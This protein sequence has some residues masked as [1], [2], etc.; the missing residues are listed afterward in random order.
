M[1]SMSSVKGGLEEQIKLLENQIKIEE[2]RS[3]LSNVSLTLHYF[4]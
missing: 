1:E 2:E 4:C 3:S